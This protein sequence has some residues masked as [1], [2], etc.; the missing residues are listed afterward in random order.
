MCNKF[1]CYDLCYDLMGNTH[2]KHLSV[3]SDEHLDQSQAEN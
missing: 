3:T 2:D 1:L